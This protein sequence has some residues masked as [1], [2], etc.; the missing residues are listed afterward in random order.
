MTKSKIPNT[1]LFKKKNLKKLIEL[2]IENGWEYLEK[3]LLPYMT[4]FHKITDLHCFYYDD[5][6]L[7][8]YFSIND[9]VL[10]FKEDK[11]SFLEALCKNGNYQLSEMESIKGEWD[12][13]WQ[14]YI[15]IKMLNDIETLRIEYILLPTNKRLDWLFKTFSQ[16]IK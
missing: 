13:D 10:D 5:H 2:A 6:R 7:V 3:D 11:T 14:E 4:N 8:D 12:D 9:L 15:E 1:N 16:L